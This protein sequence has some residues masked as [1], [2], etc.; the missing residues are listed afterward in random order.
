MKLSHEFALIDPLLIAA[1]RVIAD[2]YRMTHAL[3]W[4]A[5]L[6]PGQTEALMSKMTMDKGGG[7]ASNGRNRYVLFQGLSEVEL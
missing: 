2:D 7:E 3:D 6:G 4:E 1:L 5:G